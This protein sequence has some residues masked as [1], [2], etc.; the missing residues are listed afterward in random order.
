MSK[1]LASNSLEEWLIAHPN[2]VQVVDGSN[3]STPT[4]LSY[5]IQQLYIYLLATIFPYPMKKYQEVRT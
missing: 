4:T 2:G 5:L 3:P 1:D